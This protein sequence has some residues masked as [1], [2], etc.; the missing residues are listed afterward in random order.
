MNKQSNT[1]TIIYIIVLVIVVGTALAAT[2][3]ALRPRQQEN[4]NADKMAQILAAAMITPEKT[5]LWPTLTVISHR[6]LWSTSAARLLTMSRLS[7]LMWPRRQNLPLTAENSRSMSAPFP[8]EYR[9]TFFR[10]TAP[11]SRG[12]ISGLCGLRFRRLNNLW[13]LFCPSGRDSGTWS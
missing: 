11:A 3:L 6:S 7:M 12:P 1:Y 8:K 4:V 10:S 9:N 2:A 5:G 13:R